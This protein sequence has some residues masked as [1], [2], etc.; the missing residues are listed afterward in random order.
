[1]KETVLMNFKEWQNQL[2]H[3]IDILNKILKRSDVGT[4][5]RDRFFSHEFSMFGEEAFWRMRQKSVT[6]WTTEGWAV[7]QI[8]PLFRY[9]NENWICLTI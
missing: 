7:L 4:K 8:W 2:G 6:G 5:I 9:L 3:K 1:M